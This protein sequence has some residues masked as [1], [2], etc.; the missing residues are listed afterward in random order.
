[1]E[2][3]EQ[4]AF[5]EAK[6]DSSRTPGSLDATPETD[7]KSTTK[8]GVGYEVKDGGAQFAR[9]H[10]M[11]DPT[12]ESGTDLPT[13]T[14]A[15]TSDGSPGDFSAGNTGKTSDVATTETTASAQTG[16]EAS[17][18]EMVE[19]SNK[20]TGLDSCKNVPEESTLNSQEGSPRCTEMDAVTRAE[21]KPSSSV[22]DGSNDSSLKCVSKSAGMQDPTVRTFSD[23]S[24]AEGEI[25]VK[26]SKQENLNVELA[27]GPTKNEGIHTQLSVTNSAISEDDSSKG[28]F[29]P[30]SAIAARLKE[31]NMTLT[32]RDEVAS[33]DVFEDSGDSRPKV[34]LV[35]CSSPAVPSNSTTVE[36]APSKLPTSC[37]NVVS[38]ERDL[39]VDST[40]NK[41]QP[42]EKVDSSDCGVTSEGGVGVVKDGGAQFARGHEMMDRTCESGTDLPTVT[43]A[44]TSDGFPGDFS[45]GNTGKTSDVATTET[46]A[47]AQTGTE[48]SAKEMVE[49]S[50]KHTGLDS[51]KNVQ[52]E[53]TLSSQ[54][55]SPR[56]TEMDAV[57]R[58]EQ[59]PSSSVNDGS[60]DSS[61]KCVSKSAGMQDPTVTFSDTSHAKGDI[62]VTLSKQENLNVELA[63]GPTKNEGI[64]TQL[65]VTNSA[66][67]GDDSSK[68]TFEQSSA[69]AARLKESNMT[70]TQR[71]EVASVDVSEDRGDSRPKVE[72]V[73]CSSPAVPPNSTTVEIAPSKLPTSC[74]SYSNVVSSERDLTLDSTVNKTQPSEE[75]DSSDCGVTS[76]GGVGV[77]DGEVSSTVSTKAGTGT[78]VEGGHGVTAGSLDSPG[79]MEP[80]SDREDFDEEIELHPRLHRADLDDD[81]GI[82]NSTCGLEDELEDGLD[83]EDDD[84]DCLK[85]ERQQGDG[86]E[87][88]DPSDL[89]DKVLDFDEDKR[90]PQYIP[91][92]GAFY[93]H[94]D[95]MV[96][97]EDSSEVPEEK[98]DD[99]KG[100][101]RPKK[102]WHDEG[103]WN[104]DMYREE[105]QGPKSSEELVSIYGYDIRS[106]LMPPRARRR[107]RYGRGPN[108]YERSWEDEEAYT[109]RSGSG[110][111]GGARG[112]RRTRGGSLVENPQFHNE[113]FPDLHSKPSENTATLQQNSA[114]VKP[115]ARPAG[116]KGSDLTGSNSSQQEKWDNTVK[117]SGMTHRG[118]GKRPQHSRAVPDAPSR[119]QDCDVKEDA[120]LGHRVGRPASQSP[121]KAVE[122]PQVS[123]ST[124]RSRAIR[125]LL[126][127]QEQSKREYE[128]LKKF[129]AKG[130]L[131]DGDN[132]DLKR[133]TASTVTPRGGPVGSSE[134]AAKPRRYS[135]LRQRPLAEAAPYTETAV[136]SPQLPNTPAPLPMPN[137][138]QPAILT[139]AHFQAPYAPYSD[140]YMLPPPGQAPT[141][142]PTQNQ[143]PP[144]MAAPS[145]LSSSY[146]PPPTGI[147]SFP[148]QYPPP[149]SF[150]AQYAAPASTGAAAPTPTQAQ[151]PPYYHGDITYYNTQSQ[152]HKRPSPPRRPKVA[153]PIVPPPE[154]QG[155]SQE[156][157]PE[158][159]GVTSHRSKSDEDLDNKFVGS[160]R[161][162]RG[163]PTQQAVEK[164]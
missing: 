151:K 32:Q 7:C 120:S 27:I 84:G 94:D 130:E 61:L 58:A 163:G 5:A 8:E 148:A 25:D 97:D 147:V 161:A 153:I 86:E 73:L 116:F 74:S 108:K 65:S 71:D 107:R 15:P 95:R 6:S 99:D 111:G 91:K 26:L 162:F 44:P 131:Q 133:S 82:N 23:A 96:G 122:A 117:G 14:S 138:P 20:G 144:V 19:S 109:P 157:A 62:G 33:V 92:K 56:C 57:T 16:T 50:H 54:E 69:I 77:E 49:S 53:S 10:E 11:M 87:S 136:V 80:G 139:A 67:S 13:V 60:N 98:N 141:V 51:C 149:Y 43:S 28:T 142:M 18:K 124:G 102:L 164:L 35:L 115:S 154:S 103:V 112:G 79:C 70:L 75:V 45:T 83:E 22:N 55:G 72:L 119:Q 81:S 76:E 134:C 21:Q 9:G 63:I 41:K 12:C 39:T 1:M 52:E 129:A 31:S 59:K 46:T 121:V 4:K 105:E 37:S 24:H 140:G 125:H 146:L 145:P 123:P 156:S 126:T 88:V 159:V 128:A 118:R 113:D 85:G 78:D 38:S 101:R 89:Q 34:E 47:S 150:P 114:E 93:Q 36:I 2:F 137:Q 127:E 104:H 110:R 143:P 100:S 158:P 132:T 48:A 3:G 155:I 29:E 106:E 40:V 152:Q 30:S 66:I 90:N 68:G 17:A 135:S 160:E 64:R 42:S